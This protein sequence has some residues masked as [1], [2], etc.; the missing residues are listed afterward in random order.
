MDKNMI[1]PGKI[2]N[3]LNA[4]IYVVD[5][6]RKIIYWGSAAERITGWTA[7]DVIGT[8]CADGILCHIDK[9]GHEL[10]SDE[11]CPLHRAIV[12][13]KSSNIP[14]IVFAKGKDG[15]RIPMKVSVAPMH[16]DNGNIIGG[17]ETFFDL[18]EEYDDIRRASRIQKDMLEKT[19]PPEGH[20]RFNTHF[21]PNDIVGGDF[22]AVSK[23]NDDIYRFMIADA[24]GHGVS[25]ALFTM[26]IDLLWK[27]FVE[28][29]ES[30]EKL[31]TL[32]SQRLYELVGEKSHF[33]AAICG[34]IDLG[35]NLITI[36]G[37]GAPGPLLFHKD[38]TVEPISAEG[39][40]FGVFDNPEYKGKSTSFRAG[41]RLLVFTDGAIEISDSHEKILGADGLQDILLKQGYPGKEIDF[42]VLENAM[43]SYSDKIRFEDDVTFL[44]MV[45]S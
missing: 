7:K 32:I 19:P 23:V 41:D 13:G 25:A 27:E 21:L 15:K 26:Y 28:K 31:T 11:Y 5:P 42:K 34:E 39:M 1:D 2:L 29:A 35:K 20:I 37:A 4:G 33:V 30:L 17:I 18:S 36:I 14:I 43:L 45:F 38:G 24:A 10:C 8:S 16:D 12:T 6:D 22:Y 9:D 40:L 44:E 3:S